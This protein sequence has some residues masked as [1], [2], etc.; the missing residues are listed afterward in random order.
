MEVYESTADLREALLKKL[1]LHFAASQPAALTI[2]VDDATTYQQ[3]DGFGASITDSSAHVLYGLGP[4]QRAAAMR[5]R[6]VPTETCWMDATS[7]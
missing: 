1:P 5:D 3:M 7:S 4:Q 2:T 6:T